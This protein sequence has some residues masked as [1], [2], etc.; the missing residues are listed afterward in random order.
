M[1]KKKEEN[2]QEKGLAAV[3]AS[4]VGLKTLHDKGFIDGRETIYHGTS[5]AAKKKI[6]TEGLMGK[7][8]G[9]GSDE[10]KGITQ[11]LDAKTV[12]A[13]KGKVFLDRSRGGAAGYASQHVNGDRINDGSPKQIA[14]MF[15][16]MVTGNGIV[17]A[18]VPLHSK[19]LLANPETAM[20]YDAWKQKAAPFSPDFQAKPQFN[21]MNK[22]VV[23]KGNLDSNYIKGANYKGANMS[24]YADFLAHNKVKA[25]VGLAGVAGMG[26]LGAYGLSKFKDNR[27]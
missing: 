15:K 10:A 7:Y 22:A 24:E 9:S 25:G 2:K 5:E 1:G 17:K 23:L 8:T 27:G 19:E 3:G 11:I 18:R 14:Q 12:G 21:E 16:S 20:G 4:A 6:Q 13:S 26:A